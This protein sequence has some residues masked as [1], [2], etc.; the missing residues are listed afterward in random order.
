[1]IKNHFN[2]NLFMCVKD[3][4]SF[5]SSNKYWICNNLFAAAD[6]K[7]GDH[8]H[9]TGIYRGSSHWRCNI[10]FKFN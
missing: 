3:E 5:K 7:I 4:R 6:N 9:V 2:K 10:N 1:M 8:E